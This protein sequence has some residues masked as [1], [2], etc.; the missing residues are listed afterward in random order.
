MQGRE[1]GDT[2]MTQAGGDGVSST[3]RRSNKHLGTEENVRGKVL[4]CGGS[5]VERQGEEA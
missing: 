5:D 3:G 2:C 1:L 4:D